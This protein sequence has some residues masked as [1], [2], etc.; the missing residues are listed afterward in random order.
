[1]NTWIR[2][3][4]ITLCCA[5]CMAGQSTFA[6]EF[7]LDERQILAKTAPPGKGLTVSDEGFYFRESGASN[8]MEYPISEVL[9]FYAADLEFCEHTQVFQ[10]FTGSVNRHLDQALIKTGRDTVSQR[11]RAAYLEKRDAPPI[12]PCTTKSEAAAKAKDILYLMMLDWGFEDKPTDH[13]TIQIWYEKVYRIGE[14][15]HE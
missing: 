7:N 8:P 6:L 5:I 1:M 4:P 10:D 3:L 11:I 14:I 15:S 9:G 12:E 13:E 2:L